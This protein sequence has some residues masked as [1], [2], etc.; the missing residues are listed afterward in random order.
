MYITS[1]E[2]ERVALCFT[3]VNV[4]DYRMTNTGRPTG[5]DPADT[6]GNKTRKVLITT[7]GL[8]VVVSNKVPV[9]YTNVL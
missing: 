3:R 4:T 7:T 9:Y 5:V 2:Y 1:Y 8:T 6:P